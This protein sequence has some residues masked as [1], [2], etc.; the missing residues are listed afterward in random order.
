M[1]CVT[2]EIASAASILGILPLQAAQWCALVL[3][4]W[5]ALPTSSAAH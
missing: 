2:N 5:P 4:V 3:T 1:N